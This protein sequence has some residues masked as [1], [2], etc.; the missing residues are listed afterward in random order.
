[1]NIRKLFRS[2]SA[3]ILTVLSV[4]AQGAFNNLNFE[5]AN[6]INAGNREYPG[7]VTFASALPDWT[8]SIADNPVTQLVK[9]L[10]G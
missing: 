9:R 10:L 8:G 5:Q 1:M 4:H 7:N 3:I 6:P 2:L